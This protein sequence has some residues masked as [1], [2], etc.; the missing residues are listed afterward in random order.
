MAM[1]KTSATET[2]A[3][4][5]QEQTGQNVF[6]CYQCVKCTSGCPLTSHFDLMPNQV[7]RSVQLNSHQVLESKT[8]WLCASCETCTTR[9]PQGLDIAAVMDG[10]RIE[11]RN[12]GLKPAVP[13]VDRFARL[14]LTDL[15]V[16]GRLHEVGLMAG[17]NVVNGNL[18]KDMDLALEM[19][20]H[21]KLHLVSLPT[22][23]PQPGKVQPVE[24]AENK[25]AYYP[26][27][28]LHS[29]AREYSK[30]LEAVA[31]AVDLD[32]VEPPGWILLRLQRRALYGP[33][34]GHQV[35]GH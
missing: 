17:L 4:T 9:C 24:P 31:E 20:K 27:C 2:L 29:S 21:N 18:F 26:G 33:R 10:L 12:Q 11:A 13:E 30:S 8:I 3:E 22:R 16:M 1:S 25:I 15:K 28:S 14:F 6:L 23:S 19:L 34:P 35:S 32:L 5:L 7:M